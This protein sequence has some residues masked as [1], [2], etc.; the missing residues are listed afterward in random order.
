MTARREPVI[1]VLLAV[2]SFGPVLWGM[3]FFPSSAPNASLAVPLCARDSTPY[4]GSVA[5]TP[6]SP[7]LFPK[8]DRYNVSAEGAGGVGF[9]LGAPADFSGSWAATSPTSVFVINVSSGECVTGPPPP[10]Q[11]NE[12]FN[13][14]L[15]P[16]NYV[17]LFRGNFGTNVVLTA[18]QPWRATFDRGLDVLQGP[19]QI[20]VAPNGH[21][22]WT[23]SAPG[24]ASR[25]FIE[26]AMETT[27]C[28]FELAMLPPAAYRAFTAGR[29]PLNASGA[30]VLELV[31][32]TTP[33]GTISCG[34]S[35]GTTFFWWETGPFNWTSSD[36]VVFYNAADFTTTL[37]L[38]APLE[39]SYLAG[40]SSP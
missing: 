11:L 18:T 1:V 21:A 33:E 13:I 19:E 6:Q 9:Q 27:S 39:I 3:A 7:V 35:S 23:V 4:P 29:G 37:Y 20:A 40:E 15:F 25:F 10:P 12:T 30:D 8:L 28:D 31:V 5:L 38:Y 2:L 17:V 26:Y 24:N 14:T 22:A 34:P 36:V 32:E 16:G